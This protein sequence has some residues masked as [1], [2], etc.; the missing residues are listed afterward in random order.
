MLVFSS[1]VMAAASLVS[2]GVATAGPASTKVDSDYTLLRSAPASWVIGT[3]YRDWS[4]RDEGVPGTYA[5]ARVGGDLHRCVWIYRDATT[6]GGRDVAGSCGAPRQHTDDEFKR[7]FTNGMI[8]SNKAG[9]DGAPALLR[10]HGDCAVHN[11]KVDG[12]GNVKP[13]LATTEPTRRLREALTV[14]VDG[15]S[16][17]NG[18]PVKWRYVTRDGKFVMVHATRYDPNEGRGHQNWFFVQRSCLQLNPD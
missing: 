3:A 5:W 13:W 12:W 11:G 9:N 14:G 10:P 17:S 15:T 1:L 8:G 6:P 7:L 2:T 18:H 4:A 16:T